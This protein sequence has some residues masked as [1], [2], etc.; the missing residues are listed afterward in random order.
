M[1]LL[2]ITDGESVALKTIVAC[3]AFLLVV[4]ATCVCMVVSV[5]V[6]ASFLWPVITLIAAFAGINAA[7]FAQFRV[8]DYGYVA[9]KGE[10][11]AQVAAATKASPPTPVVQPPAAA[12]EIHS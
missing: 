5:K 7:T 2:N 1:T 3:T 9:R 10:A 6:D 12:V 4:I 8:S 11:D